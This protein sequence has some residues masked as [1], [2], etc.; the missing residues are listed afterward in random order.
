MNTDI[1]CYYFTKSAYITFIFWENFSPI[2]AQ[3]SQHDYEMINDLT[4][5]H[6]LISGLIYFWYNNRFF[7]D[8]FKFLKFE[9]KKIKS[10]WLSHPKSICSSSADCMCYMLFIRVGMLN[11]LFI[12]M[13]NLQRFFLLLFT[14]N[15]SSLLF[16]SL[17]FTQFRSLHAFL[18]TCS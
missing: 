5:H 17:S 1:K 8:F 15:F 3:P 2:R 13:K 14:S 4:L 11:C 6:S 12:C 9:N 18:S 16:L 7:A 10:K